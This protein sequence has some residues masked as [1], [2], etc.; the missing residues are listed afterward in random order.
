MGKHQAS[1][2][3]NGE[4]T[5]DGYETGEVKLLD[6]EP[7]AD[8]MGSQFP[9]TKT[10][11]GRPT[12]VAYQYLMKRSYEHWSD[13]VDDWIVQLEDGVET[14]ERKQDDMEREDVD[15]R[16]RLAI[17]VAIKH[18]KSA[19]GELQKSRRG[20][21]AASSNRS[22]SLRNAYWTDALED[23]VAGL[24]KG[25]GILKQKSDYLNQRDTEPAALLA[26]TRAIKNMDEAR[27]TL[28]N[29]LRMRL[30]PL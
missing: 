14:L 24:K 23:Q 20:K 28:Q 6:E 15:L 11:Q 8:G 16:T 4:I 21:A 29:V 1:G 9:P 25:I 30:E 19:L 7:L 13:V 22:A 27:F 12:R 3:D 26:I 17:I 18:M 10:N 5:E 2:W